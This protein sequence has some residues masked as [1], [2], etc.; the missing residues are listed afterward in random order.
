[1]DLY[2]GLGRIGDEVAFGEPISSGR[3]LSGMS[4]E[5]HDDRLSNLFEVFIHAIVSNNEVEKFGRPHLKQSQA[6]LW[7]HDLLYKL[8]IEGLI[9]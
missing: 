5:S 8:Y 3:G 2:G 6:I 1:M 7:L 4:E 9:P